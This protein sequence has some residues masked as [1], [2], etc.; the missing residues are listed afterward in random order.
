MPACVGLINAFT[1]LKRH[2]SAGQTYQGLLCI[3]P[4]Y[5]AFK[6]YDLTDISVLLK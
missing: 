4:V 2:L 6:I 5:T 3:E 1:P